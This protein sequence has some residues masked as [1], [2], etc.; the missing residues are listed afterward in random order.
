MR[1]GGPLYHCCL[2]PQGCAN[3]GEIVLNCSIRSL[4]KKTVS[5]GLVIMAK[6]LSPLKMMRYRNCIMRE[7]TNS[8][9]VMPFLDTSLW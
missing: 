1:E 4:S 8:G 9:L 6:F 2:M 5:D 3:N 7:V